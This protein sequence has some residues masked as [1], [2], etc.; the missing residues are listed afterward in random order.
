MVIMMP[1]TGT[2][3][4]TV[5]HEPVD[6]LVVICSTK[7]VPVAVGKNTVGWLP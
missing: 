6:R 4:L 1:L 2:P 5:T 7:F 3:L